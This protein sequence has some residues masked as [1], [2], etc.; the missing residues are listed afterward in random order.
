MDINAIRTSGIL[1]LYALGLLDDKEVGQVSEYLI[2][3][4]ELQVDLFDI[5]KALQSYAQTYGIKPRPELEEEIVNEVRSQGG[6][7]N[8]S[9][10]QNSNP[11][12]PK[13]NVNFWLG[14]STILGLMALGTLWYAFQNIQSNERLQQELN[15]VAS[16]CDSIT[17]EKD[18]ELNLYKLVLNSE[19]KT[20]NFTPTEKFGSIEVLLYNNNASNQNFIKVNNFPELKEGQVLQLWS[21]MPNQDPKPLDI[22]NQNSELIIPVQFI[23]GTKTYAITIEEAGGAQVPN[24]ELLIGTV[25]V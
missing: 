13:G 25:N 6:F 2:Q 24:L 1:E 3:F 16:E 5:Q 18:K 7:K 15:V 22:F 17:T 19:T 4:P 23:P 14:L 12:V 21:L 11:S 9:F 10:A 20:L 8:Q